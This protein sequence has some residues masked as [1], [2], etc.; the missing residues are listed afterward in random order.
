MLRHCPHLA[1]ES[2]REVHP[3]R[4]W[5][6]MCFGE[7]LKG[8]LK[9]GRWDCCGSVLEKNK[10]KLALHLLVST[11]SPTPALIA[12][13]NIRTEGDLSDLNGF[14][15]KQAHQK[16]KCK[17]KKNTWTSW[18]VWGAVKNSTLIKWKVYLLYN[19]NRV[20]DLKKK[21]TFNKVYLD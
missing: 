8:G 20:T 13:H 14:G 4:W 21:K 11:V 16:N 18:S 15:R 19:T 1:S 10:L 3:V 12:L 6:W 5:A 2:Y 7:G 17:G 9:G